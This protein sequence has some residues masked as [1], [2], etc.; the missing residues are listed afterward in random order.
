LLWIIA[1]YRS[2]IIKSKEQQFPIVQH[3]KDR[4]L[5]S[6]L[7][8]KIIYRNV[9]KEYRSMIQGTLANLIKEK[10]N[11]TS[12]AICIFVVGVIGIGLQFFEPYAMFG[13]LFPVLLIMQLS[14]PYLLITLPSTALSSLHNFITHSNTFT[15]IPSPE[16]Q[17]KSHT[18]NLLYIIPL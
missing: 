5:V 17:H 6:D 10:V 2:D 12:I 14:I 8:W 16:H 11:S 15:Y 13:F 4:E 3:L 7:I 9:Q 18:Q 1:Y